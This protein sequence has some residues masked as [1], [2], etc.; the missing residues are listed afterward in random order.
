[1]STKETQTQK[2]ARRH[3]STIADTAIRNIASIQKMAAFAVYGVLAIS[4]F[5]QAQYLYSI[6]QIEWVLSFSA[7]MHAITSTVGAI[8]IPIVVDVFVVICTKVV[9]TVGLRRVAKNTAL[10]L[11]VVPVAISGYINFKSSISI[12]VAIIYLMVVA[13]IPLTELVRALSHEIDY[14]AI[15]KME[16]RTMASAE[17]VS[18]LEQPVAE[19]ATSL[20]PMSELVLVGEARAKEFAGYDRMTPA[21]K[22]SWSRRFKAAQRRLEREM[23][24]PVASIQSTVGVVPVS[25]AGPQA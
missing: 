19:V 2:L 3:V 6:F 23:A 24:D 18:G 16:L 11:V 25:P 9:S 20:D 14:A 8:L 17:P 13:L 22:Q 7:M 15:E 12:A 5:H 1:M 4:Y 21:Q 10:C